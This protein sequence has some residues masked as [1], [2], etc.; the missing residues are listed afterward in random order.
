METIA[1]PVC[2]LKSPKLD[3]RPRAVSVNGITI[4]R[5]DIA[6]ETQNHAAATPI[7]AW[8]GATRALVI[9]ELLRQEATQ[10]AIVATPLEDDEGRRETADEAA[11]RALIDTDVRIPTADEDTCRRYYAANVTKFRSAPLYAARHILVAAA[12]GDLEGRDAA[13]REVDRLRDLVEARPAAFAGLALTHS[14]CPSGKVGGNLGQIGPGQTVREFETALARMKPEQSAVVETRYGFHLVVLD[15]KV[16][17]AAIPFDIV[18]D[19][20]AAY[21]DETVRR[22]AMQSYVSHL[23]G[24]AT[25]V[26]IDLVPQT[27][28]PAQ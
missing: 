19:A 14:A 1:P 5:G 4:P 27:Q 23:A 8:Q 26:G 6:R 11:M 16:E 9:R 12:P 3:T 18:R 17:G 20:I 21:L 22:K 28:R 10:R 25:I 15:R 2:D 13:R 24:R 7:A